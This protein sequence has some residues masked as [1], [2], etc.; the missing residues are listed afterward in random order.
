M[1]GEDR[2]GQGY[3]EPCEGPLPHPWEDYSTR[4]VHILGGRWD[5]PHIRGE[6]VVQVRGGLHT[7]GSPP[8]AWGRHLENFD[9][10]GFLKLGIPNFVQLSFTTFFITFFTASPWGGD[11]LDHGRPSD[12]CAGRYPG[13]WRSFVGRCRDKDSDDRSG[14]PTRASIGG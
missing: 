5:H 12:Q 10:K 11:W 14:W 1:R 7:V 9:L 4:L 13:P 6:D 8:R 3:V 2:K